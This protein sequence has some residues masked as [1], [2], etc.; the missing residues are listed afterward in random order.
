MN[1]PETM[2]Q[3]IVVGTGVGEVA[4]AWLANATEVLDLGA[5]EQVQKPAVLLGVDAEAL[6]RERLAEPT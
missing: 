2:S 3:P 6:E 5:I 1:N 4:D